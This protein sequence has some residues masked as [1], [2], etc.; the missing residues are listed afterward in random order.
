[1]LIRVGNTVYDAPEGKV[2]AF[3]TNGSFYSIREGDYE[4][5][6]SRIVEACKMAPV[7]ASVH[8]L[9]ALELKLRSEGRKIP[10][11]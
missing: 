7:F 4:V 8:P 3:I 5:A 1:M 10:W 6:D 2:V 9:K 11:E